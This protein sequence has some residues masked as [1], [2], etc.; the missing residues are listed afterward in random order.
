MPRQI[1]KIDDTYKKKAY[2]ASNTVVLVGTSRKVLYIY[3]V[4]DPNK[5]H[6]THFLL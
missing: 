6:L 5:A 2:N 4:P 3:K 1:L